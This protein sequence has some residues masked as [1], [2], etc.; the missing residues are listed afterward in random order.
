MLIKPIENTDCEIIDISQRAMQ[1]DF[2]A[3][4][5][6][7]DNLTTE[8]LK[9]IIETEDKQQERQG[10]DTIPME[11]FNKLLKYFLDKRDYRSAFWIVLQ[12][13]TGLRYSDVSKFR[14]IDLLDKNNKF[15]ESILEPEQKTGKKRINFIN[16]A[17]KMITLIYLWN[18]PSIKPLDLM[19][20]ANPNA[21][22]KGYE[23]ET[24][25]NSKGRKRC[26]KINGDFV[27]K[28]DKYG[29]KIPTPLSRDRASVIMRDALIDGLGIS[30]RND[31]RTKDNSDAY[32]KLASHSFRKA[33]A[34]A[35]IEQFVKLF[36]SDIAYAHAAAM[37]QLQYDLNHSS[38]KMTY[39][40]IGDYAE[41]KKKTNM[42]MN[43]GADILLPYFI[44]EKEKH[45]RKD[46]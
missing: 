33:Y 15:R 45:C 13:N 23:K 4:V 35:V 9:S 27:Y 6:D 22:N 12:C 30:I 1:F 20:T 43:L 16:D 24:Y 19:I 3:L 17:I 31:K 11:L 44:E 8:E 41:T 32:L 18:V 39:H 28:L 40:Y 26:V 21:S 42:N 36:N 14:R 37:E 38:R 5:P 2:N 25:I 7:T 34:Q 46:V 29:N 10:D